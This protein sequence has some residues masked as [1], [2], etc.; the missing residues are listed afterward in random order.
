MTSPKHT[1]LVVPAAIG[2]LLL[3]AGLLSGTAVTHVVLVASEILAGVALYWLFLQLIRR[4]K[5]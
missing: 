5:S 3:L 1:G 4:D 2:A